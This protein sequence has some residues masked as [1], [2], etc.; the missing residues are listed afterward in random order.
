M[1]SPLFYL[2]SDARVLELIRK[3]DE[4]ALVI[5]YKQ[6]RTMVASYVTR[7]SGTKDD[8]EDMLQESLIALWEKVKA[9]K[10]EY[11]AKLSTFIYA[12]VRNLWSRKLARR[13]RELPQAS[14]ADDPPDEAASALE[15]LIEVETTNL[16]R[17]AMEKLGEQC[18][19]ILLLFY[20][21][22]L[23]MDQIAAQMGLANA[24]TA[25]AKKYQCKRELESL[26]K[27]LPL[28]EV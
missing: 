20:W 8:A 14:N 17:R 2:D 10:F 16:V 11:S 7:N 9:G 5:L 6:N 19:K 24:D 3:G 22:D 25:K 26:M 1:G 13:R 4:E 27:R 12:T 23:T 15:D 18:R 21:E 28:D